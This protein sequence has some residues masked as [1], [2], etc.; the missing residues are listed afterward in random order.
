MG[1]LVGQG[2]QAGVG[3][4]VVFA[5]VGKGF[6]APGLQDDFEGFLKAFPAFQVVNAHRVVG[7]DVAAAADAEFKAALADLVHGG[8]FLGD[9]QGM[10]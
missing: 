1:F 10:H 4:V 7:A 2:R 5:F 3:D 6:A 9:P 8:G